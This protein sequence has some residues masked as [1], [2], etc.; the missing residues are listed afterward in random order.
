ME[1]TEKKDFL[2]KQAL[3]LIKQKNQLT[4]EIETLEM[5]Q[6]N[7]WTHEDE[8]AWLVSKAKLANIQSVLDQTI[9]E[10]V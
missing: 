7:K 6:A 10:I 4:K 2:T 1:M 9:K 5:T 8:L 3:E